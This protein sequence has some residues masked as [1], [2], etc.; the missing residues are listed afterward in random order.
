MEVDRTM[1]NGV[2]LGGHVMVPILGYKKDAFLELSLIS[3]FLTDIPTSIL[4]QLCLPL[5]IPT[6]KFVVNPTQVLPR[7][8]RPMVWPLGQIAS[9]GKELNSCKST[10]CLQGK[11]YPG[12]INNWPTLWTGLV[13]PHLQRYAYG[14][15]GWCSFD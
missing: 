9:F 2:C 14:V 10:K 15:F 1:T 8:C 6:S 7:R 13:I 11:C 3:N 5:V 12:Q 4:S